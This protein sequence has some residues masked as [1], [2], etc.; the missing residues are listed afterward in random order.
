MFT[1]IG[2][3]CQLFR[4]LRARKLAA[5]LARKIEIKMAAKRAHMAVDY[6]Q[7]N[8]FSSVVLY[9]IAHTSTRQT[10]KNKFNV[11]RIIYRWKTRNVS[12]EVNTWCHLHVA[13]CY[14]SVFISSLERI[15]SILLSGRVGLSTNV[16]G[17][18]KEH[19]TPELLRVHPR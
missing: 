9:D 17:N 18:Q 3:H 7:L 6:N 2:S 12:M 10:Y 16:P 11:K 19:L 5:V 1:G 13:T 4:S 8:S 15:M 14:K